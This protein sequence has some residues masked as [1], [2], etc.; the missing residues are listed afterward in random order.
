MKKKSKQS[1][2][3]GTTWWKPASQDSRL[4]EKQEPLEHEA[5][6]DPVQVD[7]ARADRAA[8]GGLAH[9]HLLRVPQIRERHTA[10]RFH[11]SWRNNGVWIKKQEPNLTKLYEATFSMLNH[12]NTTQGGAMSIYVFFEQHTPVDTQYPT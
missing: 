9:Q 2:S 8:V 12:P 3:F 10:C 5:V 6:A 1:Q 11:V 4:G 7:V